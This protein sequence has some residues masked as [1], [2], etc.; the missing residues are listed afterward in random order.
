MGN[1]IVTALSQFQSKL[2]KTI[3]CDRETEF[4]KWKNIEGRLNF[5][6]FFSDPYCAW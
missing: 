4:T 6:V 1:T 3:T 5:E 2:V